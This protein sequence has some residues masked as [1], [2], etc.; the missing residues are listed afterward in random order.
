[1]W[2]FGNKKKQGLGVMNTT[3]HFIQLAGAMSIV[4][5]TYFFLLAPHFWAENKWSEKKFKEFVRAALR[6]LMEKTPLLMCGESRK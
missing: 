6:I 5:T 3:L 1:L 2:P 4:G